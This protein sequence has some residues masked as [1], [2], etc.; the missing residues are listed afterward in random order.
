MTFDPSKIPFFTALLYWGGV[1]VNARLIRKR[2][3]QSPSLKPRNKL[4]YFLWLAWL[5]II[6]L[7]AATP[8]I[9]SPVLFLFPGQA[10]IGGVLIALGFIGT[11]MCYYTLGNAWAISVNKGQTNELITSGPYR[12]ARHPIY[13]LQWLIIFGNFFINPAVSLL[14]SLL[15]LAIAMQFKARYEEIALEE[16]FGVDYQDYRKRTG[17]FFPFRCC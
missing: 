14:L 7:W 13:S 4:D 15:I 11:W 17:R 16:I 3:G 1:L 6:S 12:F 8:W 10:I 9:D 5:A 2:T